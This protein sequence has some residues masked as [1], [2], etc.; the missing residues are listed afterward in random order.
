LILVHK[1][2]EPEDSDDD[3]EDLNCNIKL[4]HLEDLG[5]LAWK[6]EA[7]KKKL[8]NQQSKVA[9]NPPKDPKHNKKIKS[10]K[11]KTVKTMTNHLLS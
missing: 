1:N 11:A 5:K 7:W 10:D 6:L 2:Q 3:D 9:T 4:H 8:E